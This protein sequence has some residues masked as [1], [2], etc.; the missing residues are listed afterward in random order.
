MVQPSDDAAN[1]QE[2]ALVDF[3]LWGGVCR[4]QSDTALDEQIAEGA[5]GFKAFMCDSD[6]MFPGIDDAQLLSTL[7]HLKGTP[8]LFGLHAESDALQAGWPRCRVAA[9]LTLWLTTTRVRSSSR[10]RP[11]TER[12]SSPRR[13]AAGS[14]S[15]TSARRC[16]RTRKQAKARGVRVTAETCPQYLALDHDDLVRLAGFAKCAPA[17]RD[18]D[19]VEQLWGYLA[20]GTLDCI[21]SDHCGYTVESKERGQENIWLAPNG[22]SGA[23]ASP[24]HG[25]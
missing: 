13:R 16:R 24:G 4:G 25:Q 23:D 8:Y 3:A 11:S 5:V 2:E 10:L 7:Q 18:R 14:T 1:W 21:T 6:P 9:A 17:I 15:F 20:D 22:L 12:S 19:Q